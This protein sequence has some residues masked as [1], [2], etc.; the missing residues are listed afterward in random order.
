MSSNTGPSQV[1]LIRHGEKLGDP[2]KDKKIDG[3]DLSIQGSARAAA[4]PSLFAPAMPQLSCPLAAAASGFNG[5][6]KQVQLQGTA[7]RFS[8]PAFIFAT[9]Q[10]SNSN[11]PIETVTPLA[12]ALGLTINHGY[13]EKPKK[14]TEMAKAILTDPTYAGQI[15]L[16]CWHHGTIGD[17]ATALGVVK[18]PKW[19]GT[20]F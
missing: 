6:Y 12:S 20:V 17:V 15:V 18:P 2:K 10:S 1:L 16:I 4:L 8:P 13:P 7:A 19:K 14:I 9:R 11:R 5:T 3:P